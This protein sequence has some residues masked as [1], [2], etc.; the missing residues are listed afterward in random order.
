MLAR[1]DVIVEP[2]LR[3]RRFGEMLVDRSSDAAA[4]T[5]V[6]L[7]AS[8]NGGDP[9]ARRVCS[10]L[11]ERQRLAG[12]LPPRRLAAI[13]AALDALGGPSAGLLSEYGGAGSASNEETTPRPRDPVGY[14]IS[15]ARKHLPILIERLLFDPDVRV[16]QTV[17]ANPRLTEAE[18]LK[19][20]AARRANPDSLRAIAEDA[21]WIARYPVKLALAS[22]PATPPDLVA[23]ILPHLLD[24]DLRILVKADGRAEVRRQAGTLLAG[25]S[26]P[27]TGSGSGR[28]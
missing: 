23:G 9:R 28:G 8:V 19:L 7:Q 3:L 11:L 2:D 24:Q 21:N 1:L 13:R 4:W 6:E 14:R 20:S 25:R 22:N 26:A 18:V 5:L 17:L 12:V 27:R 15:Q 16:V 10:G